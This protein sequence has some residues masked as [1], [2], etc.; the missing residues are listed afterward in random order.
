MQTPI[1]GGSSRVRSVNAADNT[2]INLFPEIIPDG[3]KNAA[4]LS[5]APGLRLLATVGNGPIRGLWSYQGTAYVVSG[6]YLYSVDSNWASTLIG[7]VGGVGSVSMADN[8]TQL[9]IAANPQGYIYNR[10]TS[11]FQEI[12]D[13]DFPGAQIV[14][15]LDGFFVFTQPH[16]QQF[17]VTSLLEG[18]E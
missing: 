2:M 3:G 11:V 4:F 18:T 14:G 16:S 17:W 15:Y 8:G 9:F 12:T 5:R 6:N 10:L 7:Y 1:L 13:P